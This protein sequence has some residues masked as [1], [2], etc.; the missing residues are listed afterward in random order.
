[1]EVTIYGIKN[2]NTVQKAII[3]FKENNIEVNFHDFKKLGIDEK[4]LDN[5]CDEFGWENV[6][7][8]N[9]T[10]FKKLDN[11]EK[12]KITNKQIAIEMMLQKNSMIKRPVI[13]S[14]K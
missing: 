3:W 9:G 14:S 6:I 8:K 7:N 4:T 10:T 13:V 12:E 5:W 11:A 1:M 2:C